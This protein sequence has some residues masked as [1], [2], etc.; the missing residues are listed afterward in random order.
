VP[1]SSSSVPL[2]QKLLVEK[3]FFDAAQATAA[4]R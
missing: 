3:Q 1:E 4:G 2:R